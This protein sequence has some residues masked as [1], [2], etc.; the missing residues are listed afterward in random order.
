MG[1]R[2]G[3]EWAISGRQWREAYFYTRKVDF[4]HRLGRVSHGPKKRGTD[5][6]IF[7]ISFA[8]LSKRIDSEA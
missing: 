8:N 2:F 3:T 5:P 1:T 7:R 4:R 6:K